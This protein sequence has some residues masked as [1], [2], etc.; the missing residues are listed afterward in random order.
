[1]NSSRK[2]SLK[3]DIEAIKSKGDSFFFVHSDYLKHIVQFIYNNHMPDMLKS[4]IKCI[5]STFSIAQIIQYIYHFLFLF[6]HSYALTQ[7]AFI[8]D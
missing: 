6:I 2:Q 5:Y 7:K 4:R 8:D 3:Y 1:M